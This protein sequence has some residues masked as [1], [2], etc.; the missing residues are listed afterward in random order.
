[1]DRCTAKDE[2]CGKG[3]M[4]DVNLSNSATEFKEGYKKDYK[5]AL[6]WDSLSKWHHLFSPR[7]MC[8]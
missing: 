4:F 8:W 6:V 3:F 5:Q 2:E 7:R 1:M